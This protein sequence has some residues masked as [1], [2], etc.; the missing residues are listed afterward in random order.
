MN[1]AFLLVTT[2]WFA[3]ADPA[4]ATPATPHAGAVASTPVGGCC[5]GAGCADSCG[6]CDC[7]CSKPGLL[8]RLFARRC[9]SCDCCN[10]CCDSCATTNCCGCD[11]CCDCCGKPGFFHRLRARHNCCCNSCCD[12]CCGDGCGSHVA[13]APMPGAEPIKTLPKDATP[14]KSGAA[15]SQNLGLTPAGSSSILEANPF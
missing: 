3:G 6:C 8:Q 2:A 9:N 14:K 10:T 1:A 13:P 4:P 12:S 5:G 11:S 7:C 15:Q